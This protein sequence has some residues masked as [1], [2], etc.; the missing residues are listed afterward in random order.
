MN[1]YAIKLEENK[2]PLF[3]PIY[4]LD[5]VELKTL[6][7]YIETNLANSFIRPSK[8]PAGAS[9]LFNR[10]PDGS[11]RLYMNYWGL[12]N[13]TI[14]NRYLLFLIGESLNRIGREKQFTQLNLNNAYHRMRICEG[15]E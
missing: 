7:S 12:N 11:L 13:I 10:K 1:E 14:K 3:G 2:Q 4:S 9:I 5:P 6:K 15:D 8:S